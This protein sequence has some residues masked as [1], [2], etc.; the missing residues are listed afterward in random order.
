M[1]KRIHAV[2]RAWGH[3]EC[4]SLAAGVAFYAALSL[5]PLMMVLVAGVGYFFRF[6]PN[7]PSARQEILGLLSRQMKPEFS[8]SMS[9]VLEQVQ[10]QPLVNGPLAGL[11]FVFTASLVFAQIDRGFYRIWEVRNLAQET[12]LRGAIRK[13][14]SSRVRSFVMILAVGV[15]VLTLFILGMGIRTLAELSSVELSILPQVSK[16]V[17]LTVGMVLN[18]MVLTLLYRYLSKAVVTWKL[19]LIAGA[20]AAAF[21]EAGSI[22]MTMLSFEEKLSAYGL[23]GS[24]LVALVWIYYTVMVL[25]GGALIVRMEKPPPQRLTTPKL[26]SSAVITPR[27]EDIGGEGGKKNMPG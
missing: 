6:M 18:V 8:D 21:W 4:A 25:F 10:D 2:A 24:F 7:G 12:G 13:A 20:I 9:Q 5:L 15:L 11:I 19:S 23:I 27:R 26:I 22:V 1:L 16:V 3:Y 17:S 14:I